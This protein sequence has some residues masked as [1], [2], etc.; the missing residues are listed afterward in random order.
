MGK[1]D[2]E[3]TPVKTFQKILQKNYVSLVIGF[4]ES[5]CP[6]VIIL[7]EVERIWMGNLGGGGGES[8]DFGG[9]L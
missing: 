7:G 8:R 6:S 1:A 9:G 3:D 4:N 5:L 2:R